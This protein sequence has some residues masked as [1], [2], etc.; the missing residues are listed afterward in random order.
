M[1]YADRGTDEAVFRGFAEA[2]FG[3]FT[4]EY[5]EIYA[6][7]A[8][9][10]ELCEY[11]DLATVATGNLDATDAD[12]VAIATNPTAAYVLQVSGFP[13]NDGA[14]DRDDLA[15]SWDDG[16]TWTSLGDFVAEQPDLRCADT[17]SDTHIYTFR[18]ISDRMR[19]RVN[20]EDDPSTPENEFDDNSGTLQ[21]TLSRDTSVPY[22]A[23][24]NYFRLG[25]P[26]VGSAL[27]TEAQGATVPL[28]LQPG[29][30][31][32]I[33]ATDPPFF[34]GSVPRYDM[35]IAPEGDPS[36]AYGMGLY[37]D[38]PNLPGALC[39]YTDEQGRTTVYFESVLEQT[40]FYSIRAYDPSGNYQDNS[41]SLNYNFYADVVYMPPPAACQARYEMQDFIAAADIEA[42]W[43]NGV[44]IPPHPGYQMVP[45]Y[46]YVLE[47]T[48]GPWLDGA[49]PRY[50]LEVSFS[51]DDGQT[52]GPWMP[53]SDWPDACVAEYELHH[54]RV[55]FYWPSADFRARIRVADDDFANNAER[56]H[57]NLYFAG[58]N[59][60]PP[61]QA[62]QDTFTLGNSTTG[63]VPASDADGALLDLVP[64]QWYALE[65]STTAWGNPDADPPYST[66]AE[67]TDDPEWVGAGRVW[68][69]IHNY[70]GASCVEEVGDHYRIYFKAQ[71]GAE[72]FIRAADPQRTFA[73][74]TDDV[75]WVLYEVG[76]SGPE[77]PPTTCGETYQVGNW[78]GSGEI[79][80]WLEAG[81]HLSTLQPDR[82]Y[83]LETTGG[84]WIDMEP[85]ADPIESYQVD[86]SMDGGQTW[87]GIW[88][89]PFGCLEPMPDGVHYRIYFHVGPNDQV[90]LRVHDDGEYLINQ[91]SMGYV[92]YSV[93]LPTDPGDD[94]G[95]PPGFE[96]GCATICVRPSSAL[97]VPEW[98]EYGRC[99]FQRWVAWC[100]EHTDALLALRDAF[101]QY[102][103]FASI[104]EL[105]DFIAQ[106]RAEA[107]RYQ[108]ENGGPPEVSLDM[109]LP[110]LPPDSPYNGGRIRLLDPSS[111]TFST[112][113]RHDMEPAVGSLLAAGMCFGMDALRHV[114][115]TPWL[116]FFWD[117]SMVL[118]LLFYIYER[119]VSGAGAS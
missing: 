41:G 78:F 62:C 82:Y 83:M 5:V 84:P 63:S 22:N 32:A 1:L 116:Q 111:P 3:G 112:E 56:M 23:C 114:G 9:P 24:W 20:D 33:E 43:E 96:P 110:S 14:Q 31:Y 35:Q 50:D 17:G 86:I 6:P 54:Y 77:P 58:Y 36:V 13:W 81:V 8:Q 118:L 92:I 68:W 42:V 30:V 67:L 103:P 2:W 108:W 88:E 102:E 70:P 27:A 74:N 76:A 94:F 64:G 57:Y 10:F 47:T 44:T 49:D 89:A 73:G 117:L 95:L 39:T 72:Y 18:A 61:D 37:R 53:L 16:V 45:G 90:R 80:A 38:P 59:V 104:R 113:C 69:P 66:W 19:L 52:W 100:P 11:G 60:P 93:N 105:M 34:D 119:W 28:P 12:G 97:N 29:K 85:A 25:D 65:A 71:D 87:Y 7:L 4:V 26:Y 21:W 48:G 109:F 106:V 79:Q 101:Y 91:G 46:H 98:L 15:I 99:E 40:D 75:T 107:E 115:V 55:Y 51:D